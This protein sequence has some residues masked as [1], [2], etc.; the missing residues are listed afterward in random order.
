M[1]HSCLEKWILN[2]LVG[3]DVLYIYLDECWSECAALIQAW[4]N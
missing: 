4:L 1:Y 3:N 2:R